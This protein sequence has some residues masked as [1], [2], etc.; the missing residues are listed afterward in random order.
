MKI[1][2]SIVCVVVLVWIWRG[3][4]LNQTPRPTMPVLQD[5]G[6]NI[7]IRTLPEQL[8]ASVTVSGTE[9]QAPNNAF[10][11]LAWFIFGGNTS[12]TSVAMTAPVI[13]QKTSQTIAM[14]APVISQQSTSW[15]YEVSFVMPASYTLDTL[16]IPN[17]KSIRIHTMPTKTL[18]VITFDGYTT[19]DR[20]A[21]HRNLL[22]QALQ[23]SWMTMSWEPIIAQYNDPRTPRF[24]RTNEIWIEIQ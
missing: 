7:Q 15:S 24:M 10:R 19:P 11:I 18:G 22:I 13:S 2:I 8:Y 23:A 17:D 3:R 16:P 14:T 5:L 4:Y 20:I 9:T 6:N 21:T 1:F 12:K